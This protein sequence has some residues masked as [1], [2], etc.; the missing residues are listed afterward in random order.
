MV[1]N[2]NMDESMTST[3]NLKDFTPA[4]E[5]NAWTLNGPAVDSTNEVDHNTVGVKHHK[6]KI[7]SNP[8]EFTLEPHSLTAIEIDRTG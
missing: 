2:K 5:G 3:I 1:I 6:F 8:F 7:S 4:Q